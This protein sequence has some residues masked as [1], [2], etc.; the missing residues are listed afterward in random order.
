V[1]DALDECDDDRNIR[2]IIQLLAQAQLASCGHLKVLITSRPTIPIEHEFSR[3]PQESRCGL[4]LHHLPLEALHQDITMYLEHELLTIA[5]AMGLGTSWPGAEALKSL[6]DKAGGLFIWCATACRFIEE[7]GLFA[8]ERLDKLLQDGSPNSGPQE[9]LNEIYTSVLRTAVSTTYTESE[10]KSAYR[11]LRQV[12]GAIVVLSSPLPLESLCKLLQLPVQKIANMLRS[13]HAILDIPR[14]PSRSVRLHHPSFR[15]FLLDKARCN[16]LPFGV[17]EQKANHEVAHACL[18][19]MASTLRE[20]ICD[21]KSYQVLRDNVSETQ[22]KQSLPLEAQYACLFRV[23][24]IYKSKALLTDNDT[25]YMFLREHI[26][27][28]LE[29]LS[30]MRR[31]P[32]AIRALFSLQS[33]AS[34]SVSNFCLREILTPQSGQ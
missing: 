29:A 30:W 18:Q 13:L 2:I 26:L 34:V 33:M 25:V 11:F 8:Q 31:V 14:D 3:I 23:Q 24:H 10:Q 32:E 16:D 21:L 9:R 4:I 19:L 12:L 1:I 27:H 7:G 6:T 5:E 28:W 17:D 22:I 15:D 20:D